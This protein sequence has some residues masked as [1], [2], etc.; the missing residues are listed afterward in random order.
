M[1]SFYHWMA[2][3]L[4]DAILNSFKDAAKR[5]SLNR[6]NKSALLFKQKQPE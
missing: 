4:G 5:N 6:Y 2:S 3:L 1:P